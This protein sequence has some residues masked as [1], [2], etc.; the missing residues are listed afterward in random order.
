MK[1]LLTLSG[2]IFLYHLPL[3]AAEGEYAV[4]KIS[5]ALLEK[6]NAVLRLEE[7]RFEIRSTSVTVFINHYVITILNENG[8]HW[9][10][11]EEYYDKHRDIE[12]VEGVLYDANGK[13]LKKIKKKDLEDLS[14]VSGGTLMDDNRI[15]RHNFY[16]K[17][18]PYTVE[19]T[20]EITNK[21]TLFFPMWSPQGGEKLSVEKSSMSMVCPADYKFRYKAFNYAKDPVATQEKNNIVMTW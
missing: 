19:Y 6:A 12:S 20:I 8:D 2:F 21:A 9:A 1:K 16:Y 15:K 7:Q 14:G 17:V 11:F 13:Q 5:S 3:Q 4:S 18:Y 10:A